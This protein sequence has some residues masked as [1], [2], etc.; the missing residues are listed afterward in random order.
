[1]LL[2]IAFAWWDAK[3]V[4]RT[5]VLDFWDFA[6][7]CE[8][9]EFDYMWWVPPGADLDPVRKYFDL[10]DWDL[11]RGSSVQYLKKVFKWLK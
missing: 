8:G 10:K 4:L 6:A 1:L 11:L 7:I 3:L 2:T 9:W 5:S